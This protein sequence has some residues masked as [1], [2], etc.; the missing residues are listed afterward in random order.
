MTPFQDNFQL[1][2]NN[3]L[4]QCHN[5]LPGIY[6]DSNKEVLSGISKYNYSHNNLDFVWIGYL[7]IY[8]NDTCSL[9]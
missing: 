9:N 4:C 6:F 5:S 8:L 3:Y 2:I 7:F 1:V